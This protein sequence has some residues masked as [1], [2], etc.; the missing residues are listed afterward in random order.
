MQWAY[1]NAKGEPPI[2]ITGETI[3]KA[4][5]LLNDYFVPMA[6]RTYAVSSR[7]TEDRYAD[8]IVR[9]FLLPKWGDLF[10]GGNNGQF[11]ASQ[12]RASLKGRALFKSKASDKIHEGL[13]ILADGDI[14]RA[15]IPRKDK[16]RR[17]DDWQVRPD[18][19]DLINARRGQA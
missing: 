12:V 10:A 11:T 4:A 13:K 2:S 19:I 3:E 8:N 6:K 5:G 9:G 17:S 7:W 16:T 18:L 15:T 1:V 14:I